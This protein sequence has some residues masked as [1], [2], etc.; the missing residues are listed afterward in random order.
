MNK[1]AISYDLNKEGQK[2]SELIKFLKSFPDYVHIQDSFWFIKSNQSLDIISKSIDSILDSNDEY[3]ILEFD[4]HPVGK[5]A[6]DVY[7][8]L[9]R[10]LS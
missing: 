1:Y 8:D 10:F 6:D 5:V 2:Y 7:Q 9:K 3:L 4:S